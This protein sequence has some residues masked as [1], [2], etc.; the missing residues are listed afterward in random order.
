MRDR[1]I[2]E[3]IESIFCRRC[4]AEESGAPFY[5]LGNKKILRTDFA[6]FSILRSPDGDIRSRIRGFAPVFGVI[7]RIVKIRNR[8]VGG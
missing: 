8:A 3:F 6:R 5:S 4:A 7:K 1:G 2:K